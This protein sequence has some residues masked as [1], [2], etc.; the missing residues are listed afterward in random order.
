LQEIRQKYSD[1]ISV[2]FNV[3]CKAAHWINSVGGA[4]ETCVLNL[5]ETGTDAGKGVSFEERSQFVIGADGAQSAV[6]DAMEK[7]KY[8]GFFV[9]RYE[10]KNVRVYRTI[11]LH[12]P[13]DGKDA[14]KWRRDLN[15]SARTKSDINIDALPTKE[16]PYFGVV[17]YR[18]W[19]TRLKDIKTAADARAF[20]DQVLPMFSPVIRDADLEKFAKKGDSK[21]PRF[22]YAGPVLHR[23]G[24]T[25]LVGDCIHTVKRK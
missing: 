18:P 3:E 23:G 13:K 14:K 22:M 9:K 6:R 15:Y 16:G 12:F 7:D 17:L 10:D 20:F 11:P 19:D 25:C 21:L 2:K 24:S 1:S 8:K 5:L 4:D